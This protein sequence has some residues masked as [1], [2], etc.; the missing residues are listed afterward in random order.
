M[1]YFLAGAC[2]IGLALI[3][4]ALILSPR[5]AAQRMD[6][7]TIIISDRWTGYVEVCMVARDGLYCYPSYEVAPKGAAAN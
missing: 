5:Y 6:E 1:K 2:I 3:L 7:S 4:S